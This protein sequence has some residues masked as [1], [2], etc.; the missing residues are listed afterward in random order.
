M[1]SPPRC[2]ATYS[3]FDHEVVSFRNRVSEEKL[4]FLQ[5]YIGSWLDPRPPTC[6]YL[7]EVLCTEV[8][9]LGPTLSLASKVIRCFILHAKGALIPVLSWCLTYACF[10]ISGGGRCLTA[11]KRI[12]SS[13]D[14][15]SK[16][17]KCSD[18][19]T[20][21][22]SDNRTQALEIAIKQPNAGPRSRI[23]KLK[24]HFKNASASIKGCISLKS[25]EAK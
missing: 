14:L 13:Q 17:A 23:Q 12:I 4:G 20:H 3:P 8:L 18:N 11:K 10:F 9:Q 24:W 19:Q 16:M 6:H 5:E 1:F 25:P 22:R 2:W 21:A 7:A 15:G